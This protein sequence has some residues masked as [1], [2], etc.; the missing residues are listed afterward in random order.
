MY[1]DIDYGKIAC[2]NIDYWNI[3]SRHHKYRKT[4]CRNIDYRKIAC[5]DIEYQKTAC[6]NFKTMCR[7]IEIACW[8]MST[9]RP[10]VETLVKKHLSKY[11][12]PKD[13]VL[14]HQ[15]REVN[16]CSL[17][18][19]IY[20]SLG[21]AWYIPSQPWTR[22]LYAYHLYRDPELVYTSCQQTHVREPCMQ[23]THERM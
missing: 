2:R 16:F 14:K 7:N 10:R 3:A 8:D 21:L 11:Q 9:E 22:N 20:A 23:T 15:L 12:L 4:M 5:R 19:S 13:H 17:W 6:W 1:R 18:R